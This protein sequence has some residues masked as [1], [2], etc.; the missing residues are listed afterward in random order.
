M[1]R[2][3]PLGSTGKPPLI[4]AEACGQT[5]KFPVAVKVS[6]KALVSAFL[7][8]LAEGASA[9]TRACFDRFQVFCYGH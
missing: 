6:A 3:D 4:V 2:I 8:F 1:G 5:I 7:L 9:Q